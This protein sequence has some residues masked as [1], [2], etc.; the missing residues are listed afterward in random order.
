MGV[1]SKCS[2]GEGI[3]GVVKHFFHQGSGAIFLS[4]IP[5]ISSVFVLQVVIFSEFLVY[6]VIGR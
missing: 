6:L 3:V 1:I 2:L 4:F 5:S